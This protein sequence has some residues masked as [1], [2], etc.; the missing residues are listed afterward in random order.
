MIYAYIRIS[1]DKQTVK[2]QEFEI[3]EYVN[4]KEIIVD[5]WVQETVS[6]AKKVN[7]RKLGRLLKR[8]K[9]HDTLIVS[10]ISRLGRDLL[11]IMGILHF[12]MEHNLKI[13]A[14][15]ENYELGDNLNSKVLAFAFGLSAEIERQL[16]SARTKEALA[17]KR[18]EGY[19][20]GKPKDFFLKL[21]GKEKEIEFLMRQGFS[22]RE[23]REKFGVSRST[24]YNFIKRKNI[25][26]F[27][28]AKQ[29]KRVAVCHSRAL[30]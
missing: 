15:K 10:E 8:M 7:D 28:S 12:S 16:I 22:K 9:P 4:K 23:I 1:T 13:I 11:N 29:K 26:L 17:R 5:K 19:K 24:L 25:P 27:I 20:L 14:I 2:N 6:G 3:C 21:N 30:V 18:A